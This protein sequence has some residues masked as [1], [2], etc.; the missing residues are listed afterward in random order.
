M[1]QGN[2]VAGQGALLGQ[3]G[4]VEVVLILAAFEEAGQVLPRNRLL[5][6]EKVVPDHRL[7]ARL[8]G[9]RFDLTRDLVL[10]PLMALFFA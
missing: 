7:E 5:L 10:D 3:I 2:L 6:P 9:E 1:L 4:V 8:V